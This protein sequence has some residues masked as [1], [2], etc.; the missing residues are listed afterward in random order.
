V[1]Y[2]IA[3]PIQSL[4]ELIFCL[5][6]LRCGEIGEILCDRRV[7]VASTMKLCSHASTCIDYQGIQIMFQVKSILTSKQLLC[8]A[9]LYKHPFP[10]R[11]MFDLLAVS[12]RV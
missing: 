10:T 2:A 3:V 12:V 7:K 6:S 11:L 4:A 1:R 5:H 9:S 8:K